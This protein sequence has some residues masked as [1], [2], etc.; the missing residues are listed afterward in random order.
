LNELAHEKCGRDI[1]AALAFIVMDYSYASVSLT[2]KRDALL[3]GSALAIVAST[4]VKT[5]QARMP[6][7]P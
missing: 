7:I 5:S 4:I 3:A 1:P 2:V 6:L